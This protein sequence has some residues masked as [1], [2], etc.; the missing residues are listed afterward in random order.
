MTNDPDHCTAPTDADFAAKF[1]KAREDRA[2]R[3]AE[4]PLVQAE[5]VAALQR[6]FNVAN[7]HSGQCRRV[8]AFLLGC[9]NGERFPYDLTDFRCL[10]YELFADC[11]TVLRMDWQPAQEVHTYFPDGGAAFEKLAKDWRIKDRSPRIRRR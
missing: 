11:L 2:Q 8:A 6:L 7:G 4:R 5:G 10:D 1:A 9:Y 3:Q